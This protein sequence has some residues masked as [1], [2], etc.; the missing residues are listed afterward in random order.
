MP[1]S[2]DVP[3]PRAADLLVAQAT[4][5]GRPRCLEPVSVGL[6]LPR[7]MCRDCDSWG[8]E[9]WD[10]SAAPFQAAV[11]DRWSDGSIRWALLDFQATVD[12]DSAAAGTIR[13]AG[14]GGPAVQGAIA[15]TADA[16][17]RARGHRGGGLLAVGPFYR[18]VRRRALRRRRGP[19]RRAL[20]SSRDGPPTAGRARCSGR[21]RRSSWPGRCGRACERTVASTCATGG[22]TCWR[23]CTS[24]PGPPAVRV[25]FTIRNP[26]PAEQPGGSGPGRPRVDVP[27]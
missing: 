7:G 23:E 9:R 26:R 10:G 13:F 6:P 16:S 20:P 17:W 18:V 1:H 2:S 11:L 21:T 12:H 25:E 5:A 15:T 8:I 3:I 4:I 19:R 14:G 24:S 22:S 27:A